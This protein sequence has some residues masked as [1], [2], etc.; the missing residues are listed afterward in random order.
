MAEPRIELQNTYSEKPHKEVDVELINIENLLS[1]LQDQ[2]F[3]DDKIRLIKEVTEQVKKDTGPSN[4]RY[5]ERKYRNQNQMRK[6][7]Y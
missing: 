2:G 6:I 7:K 4:L 1:K 5:V 3:T